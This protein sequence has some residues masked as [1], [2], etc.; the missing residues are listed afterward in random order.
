VHASL[1]S[2]GVN[3]FADLSDRY[4]MSAVGY[5]FLAGF[6]PPNG[7]PRLSPASPPLCPTRSTPWRRT[8]CRWARS[9]RCARRPTWPSSAASRCTSPRVTT[10]ECR[11]HWMAF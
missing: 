7:S 2:D 3:A 1:W 9:V 10:Y 5:A 8:L 4:G 6:P 11:R